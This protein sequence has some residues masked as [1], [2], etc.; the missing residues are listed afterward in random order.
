M[1]C[2]STETRK[3]LREIS[4]VASQLDRQDVSSAELSKPLLRKFNREFQKVSESFHSLKTSFTAAF[5]M[6]REGDLELEMAKKEAIN[7]RGQLEI[8]QEDLKTCQSKLEAAQEE[9]KEL[10]QKLQKVEADLQE[11]SEKHL[12]RELCG[13]RTSLYAILTAKGKAKLRLWTE[14]PLL[15]VVQIQVLSSSLERHLPVLKPMNKTKRP[16]RPHK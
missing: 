15:K 2:E 3:R 10:Q 1:K 8:T 16:H 11:L 14:S 13:T 7:C 5:A 9:I 6:D 12:N 4:D